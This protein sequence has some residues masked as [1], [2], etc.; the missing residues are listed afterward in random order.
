MTS[1][2]RSKWS[3]ADRRSA[4]GGW[5]AG[6]RSR[7]LEAALVTIVLSLSSMPLAMALGLL[8]AIGRV[9]GPAPLRRS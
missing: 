4:A 7:L 2:A 9:Y 6:T 3:G 5:S 8:L 1:P